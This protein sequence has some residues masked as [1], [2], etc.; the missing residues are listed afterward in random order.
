MIPND[1]L[2][3]RHGFLAALHRLLNP[4]VYLEIGVQHG[5]SLRLAERAKIAIGIDPY[6][7]AA[8]FG[9]QHIFATTSDLFFSESS[10]S[11]EYT[12]IENNQRPQIDLAFVDGMH[13]AEYALRD[14]LNIE[15][16]AHPGTLVVLDDVLPRN[17]HEARRVAPDEEIVGDWTG[18]VWKIRDMLQWH[19]PDL[20]TVLVNTWPT[21]ILLVWGF[22]NMPANLRPTISP[23]AWETLVLPADPPQAVFDRIGSFPP[24]AAL[25]AVLDAGLGA[26]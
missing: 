22:G 2:D 12:C 5:T 1:E 26:R 25:Q 16:F 18:D 23:K 11:F 21:G 9:N 24:N 3:S 20:K 7:Q 19:R 6:P 10:R 13:H 4:A 8:T 17:T 15:R 14:L